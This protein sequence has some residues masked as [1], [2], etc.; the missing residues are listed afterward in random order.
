M[1]DPI[2]RCTHIGLTT[3]LPHTQTPKAIILVFA[4][5]HSASLTF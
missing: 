3:L 1:L 5:P 2:D 4:F